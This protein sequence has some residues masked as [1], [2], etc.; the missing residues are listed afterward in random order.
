MKILA[1]N[2]QNFRKLLQC[3]IDISNKTTIFVGANNSGKTSAM[4]A[5]GK[6]LSDRKF[7]FNDIT[8]T[9][10]ID[11]NK[12]GDGWI[13]DDCEEPT[14]LVEWDSIVPK[15]D[16][17]LNVPCDEIHYVA[18][19]IP[20]L[21]W[22]GG[23]L[24]VR[25]AFL[26]KDISKLFADYRKSYFA[27]RQTESAQTKKETDN[28]H[29][30]P[31]DLCDFL[32]KNFNTIFSIKTFI[33]NP[34]QTDFDN[35]PTTPFGMECF[36]DR[37]LK[38]IIKV[39]MI[40]A[41]RGFTDPDNPDNSET[42]KKQ[43]SE[44][45]RSYYDKHLDP[46]KAPSPEDL[47]ILK[48]TE[49]AK[50]AFDK[51][52]SIKF[53][54]AIQEL[55]ELGYPGVADPK[56]TIATKMV[57]GETLKHDAAVQYALSKNNNSLKL[58]EKYNGLGYQNLISMVFGLMRFRDDW[59]LEGKAMQTREDAGKA[60][61]PLHLVLVEEPEAHLHVQVQQ[62]FIRKAYDVLTNHKIIKHNKNFTTQLVISTHSSHIARECDFADLRYFKR[63]SEGTEENIATSKVINLSDV[64]GKEDETDKFVTRYLQTTHCDLFF[65]DA[66]ILVEGSAELMLLPHFIRNKYHGL[67]QRYISILSISGRH[68]HRLGPLIDKLCLPT[69]VVADIDSDLKDGHHKAARPKRRQELISSN[70]TI[71]KWLLKENDLDK[72]LDLPEAQKV[73]PRETPY[74]Y[75]IRVAYQTPIMINYAG[76]EKEAI[77]STFED[78]LVYTNYQTFKDLSTDDTGSLIKNVN[79]VIKSSSTFDEFSIGVYETLRSGKSEQKAEFAL[80]LIY[81]IDPSDL[82]VPDY[83]DRGLKWL[84]SCLEPEV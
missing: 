72:L 67:Y 21:K 46:E 4:D 84:Q 9:K 27:A 14:T 24:G 55:E 76:E 61:E 58:P 13:Q 11:I 30:Y 82:I 50:K 15:M 44:Q 40:D 31:K 38:G 68:S 62:V 25:L 5:L 41:Q 1:I 63:L 45:L 35:P 69:L 12:I 39:D 83:I 65:A 32:E 2:I 26:P 10:R 59:M 23:Q 18:D 16:I 29:L 70:Y 37:P 66:A 73:I 28:I 75:S 52:L 6:F 80:D 43:L 48:A 81:V 49:D 57:T 20:T 74:R 77:A 36:T 71:T 7:A 42:S 60:I 3:R 22:R 56:L 34:T 78:C 54:P 33:L 64:F 19:I 79:D 51:N 47:E 8:I 53:Q 17:W